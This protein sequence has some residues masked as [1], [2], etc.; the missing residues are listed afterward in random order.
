MINMSPVNKLKSKFFKINFKNFKSKKKQSKKF[1]NNKTKESLKFLWHLNSD[2]N[3]KKPK[4][5]L[6]KLNK[7]AN[8]F[9]LKLCKAKDFW[10]KGIKKLSDIKQK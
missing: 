7:N 4:I 1:S 9:K 5:N 3:S 6:K 10:K 8:H 2:K